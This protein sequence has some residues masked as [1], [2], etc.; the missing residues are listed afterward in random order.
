MPGRV[1]P[2]LR[3]ALTLVS[4]ALLG[5]VLHA[6]HLPGAWMFGPLIASAISAV[7]GWS[8]VKF[9]QPVYV[10][11]QAMIGT[12][13]GAGFTPKTLL[14]ILPQHLGVFT[15]AVVFILLTSL[16]NGWLL[17][18]YTKLDAGSAF[19]GTL[20]GGAG[21]MAAMSDSLGADTRLVTAIQYT[22]LLVI[23]ASLACFAPIL[24]HFAQPAAVNSP[25]F[26]LSATGPFDFG[27]FGLLVG[28]ACA[29]WLAG[30]FTRIP[31]GSFLIP[32]A[33]YFGLKLAGVTPGSWPWPLL[34][35]AY[36]VM[37]SQIGG[38]FHPSTIAMIREVIV[39]VLGTTLV[40]LLASVAL[41]WI[42]M[43]E[44]GLNF[45]SA[46]FA[47]TPGGLDSVAAVATELRVDTTIVVA[48]HLVRILCVLI[49]GPWLVRGCTRWFV[50]GSR[51]R[52]DA[53]RA[54]RGPRTKEAPV[55]ARK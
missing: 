8:A 47:A 19:L 33:I 16:L 2:G 6:L 1:K 23:L 22:R 29:G 38:R 18:R 11:G 32:T 43:R 25:A 9:P 55:S 24:K 3:L 30:L 48:M 54:A 49:A 41:A 46:Y 45:V 4:G 26:T 17:A 13:L 27:K 21:V 44:M 5:L 35:A 7:R 42:V 51:H 53:G 15:F 40:L 10:A 50:Q 36:L 52:P 20:P 14:V 28:V 39:P 34:A 12:A 37:G 31:A